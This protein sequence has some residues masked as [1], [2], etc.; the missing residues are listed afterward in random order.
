MVEDAINTLDEKR[1]ALN[2]L[3]GGVLHYRY[4]AT[5]KLV[6]QINGWYRGF[7]MLAFERSVAYGDHYSKVAALTF[8]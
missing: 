3:K 4:S 8:P 1:G 5:R 2:F 7:Y 6:Q